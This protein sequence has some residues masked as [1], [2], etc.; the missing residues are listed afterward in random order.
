M[1][2]RLSTIIGFQPELAV[3]L[4]Y[5]KSV[6]HLLRRLADKVRETGVMPA[7]EEVQSLVTSE[8]FVPYASSVTFER[9]R[10]ASQLLIATYVKRY[11]QDLFRIWETE[12]PF[13][14]HLANA[15]VAG[16][17]DVILDR[18]AGT[19]G[20][21]ALVDYKVSAA[22][23][24]DA[25]LR[26]QLQ[27]YAAAARSEG[28]DVRAAYI[29]DLQAGNRISVPVDPGV[30]QSAQDAGDKVVAAIR[31]KDYSPRPDNKKCSVCDTR[32]LCRFKSA[33]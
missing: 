21:L 32:L 25:A 27:V 13:E 31:A 24:Q 2:Y 30:I 20:T 15:I 4:G 26:F 8:F 1:A 7:P 14:L 3:E 28:L 19:R 9:L 12:R 29:H 22:K 6:H 17:A 18:E 5:G 33:A 23:Q 11:G 10:Q 16:R